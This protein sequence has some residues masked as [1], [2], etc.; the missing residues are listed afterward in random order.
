MTALTDRQVDAQRPWPG[1]VSFGEADREFFFGRDAES[2]ELLGLVVVHRLTV[3]FGLSGLGKSSLLAAGL[4][5]RLRHRGFFPVRLRFDLEAGALSPSAQIAAALAADVRRHDVDASAPE[6][7][8]PI[9]D[10]L[11]RADVELWSARNRLLTPVFVCDQF[12]EVFSRVSD[13][14]SRNR[15]RA[16][17]ETIGDLSEGRVPQALRARLERDPAL[18]SRFTFTGHRYRLLLSLRE[19]YLADL[20][21]NAGEIP[22]LR[23][24]R[25]R[26]THMRSSTAIAAVRAAGEPAGIV[27]HEVAGDI[28]RFVAESLAAARGR[29][30]SADL[31][32][33]P[34]LLSVVCRELNEERIRDGRSHIASGQLEH[35]EAILKRFYDEGV[36]G[37]PEPLR[38]FIEERLIS[39]DG[40]RELIA[41]KTMA[42]VAGVTE[43]DIARLIDERI[44]RSEYRGNRRLLE[45]THD[46]LA[47]V[48]FEN[49]ERRR[50][51]EA[52]EREAQLARA[53]S[54]ARPD[55][56]VSPLESVQEMAALVETLQSMSP[57]RM[58][59]IVFARILDSA[60]EAI[61]AERAALL[62][63]AAGGE[64]TFQIGRARGG[65]TLSNRAFPVDWDVVAI[66]LG[67][68]VPTIERRTLSDGGSG[69]AAPGNRRAIAVPVSA[70]GRTIGGVYAELRQFDDEREPGGWESLRALAAASGPLVENALRYDA[71]AR[72][73]ARFEFDF[74]IAA[75]IHQSLLPP[76]Q[77]A[78]PFFS[79]AAVS[80]PSRRVGGD[81][82]DYQEL[83]PGR[84]GFIIGDV[85]GKGLPAATL[86]S[87]TLGMFGAEIAYLH[88]PSALLERIN[89]SLLRRPIEG[90]FLTA[91][92]G[93]LDGDGRLAFASGGEVPP[94]LVSASG[95]GALELSG[96]VIG[97]LP[98]VQFEEAS[99]TLSPGD[100]VVA[101]SDGV[102]EARN[103]EGDEFGRSRV[104]TAIARRHG[105]L[106][107]DVID[108]LLAALREFCG[109]APQSDDLAI[110]VLRYDGRRLA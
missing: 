75:G 63:T 50:R 82:F 30:A 10:Y 96:M 68:N 107:Q 14:S 26:L 102:T 80:V 22:S 55:Q 32:I 100:V 61:D 38:R 91:F 70:G 106:P 21:D 93:V 73:R 11:H 87:A 33:E 77:H 95:V 56:R 3:L 65:T 34:A 44:I 83:A 29:Q 85:S 25:L 74:R 66:A 90:R 81:F 48:V 46:R 88:E 58:L 109:E 7:A 76:G 36:S 51:D 39:V 20:D 24:S 59:E 19:D 78:G 35:S 23:R 40:Q 69:D 12:E 49:R 16:I 43:S 97:L 53:A 86:V 92:L 6:A 37:A 2:E 64:V 57:E 41:Y 18:A 105:A 52:A 31:P 27:T 8:E 72:E 45:L 67:T 9:W 84:F 110:L 54:R 13:A 5:P 108:G 4:F 99:V 98:D 104:E 17:I 28:V 101:M 71:D 103:G 79:V 47:P 94:F 15:Q 62:L 89:R 1:P 60:I 42:A